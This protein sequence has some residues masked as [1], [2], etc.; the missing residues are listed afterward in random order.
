M[1]LDSTRLFFVVDSHEAN[2]EIFTTYGEAEAHYKKLKGQT[3]RRIYAG[4]VNNAYY[5]K[6]LKGWNYDDQANTFTQISVLRI[7]S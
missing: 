3:G 7:G 2:E 5:E 1:I 6:D 4:L